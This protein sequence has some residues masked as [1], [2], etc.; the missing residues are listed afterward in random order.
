MDTF[1]TSSQRSLRAFL[2]ALFVVGNQL[3][4]SSVLRR[5]LTS[6]MELTGATF[7]AIGVLDET[8]TYLAEFITA[9]ISDDEA[10]HIGARPKGEGVLGLLISDADTVNLADISKHPRSV[11]FPHDHPTMTTFLGVAIRSGSEIF[12]NLYLTNKAEGMPF[13]SSDELV[14]ESLA[15]AAGIAID[16]ENLHRR[17]TAQ[18]LTEERLRIARDLHDDVIQQ[19]FSLSMRLQIEA[20]HQSLGHDEREYV[21]EHLDGIIREIRSTISNLERRGRQGSATRDVLDNLVRRLTD[22]FGIAIHVRYEGPVDVLVDDELLEDLVLVV[23]ESVANVAKHAHARRIDVLL[24]A[25]DD[26]VLIIDDD[27]VGEGA[28]PTQ[29]GL[30]LENIRARAITHNGSASFTSNS[31]GGFRVTF[32]VPVEP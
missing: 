28:S 23:Q 13:D 4:L 11:G 6:G 17:A 26:I 16:R 32:R 14:A 3:E 10:V 5:V 22:N 24:E 12:G 27:G 18:Q 8:K 1:E 19:L 7:G 20:H 31:S 9:G 30:G 25:H 21:I 2:N 29:P 15:H